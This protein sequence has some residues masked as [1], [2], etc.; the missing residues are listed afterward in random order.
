MRKN[1]A[2]SVKCVGAAPVARCP[3]VPP[4][5]AGKEAVFTHNAPLPVYISHAA[6]KPARLECGVCSQ[7]D[8][9][10]RPAMAS[11][12]SKGPRARTT[13]FQQERAGGLTYRIPSLVH[14]PGGGVVLAFAEKRTTPDDT[15]AE[16][17]VLRRGRVNGR[18]VQW[19]PVKELYCATLPGHRTMNP[20]PVYER[21]SKTLFLFFICVLRK[22]SERHQICTGKNAARLCYVTSRDEGQSWSELTDLTDGVLGERVDW[23][24][25]AVGPGH[26][27]QTAG[28]K[29]VVPAYAY[30]VHCRCFCFPLY[31]RPHA[32]YFYSTDGGGSWLVGQ[33]V[34]RASCECEMAEVMD[35]EHRGHVY[36]NA[37]S[38]CGHRVEAVGNSDGTN[39]GKPRVARQLVEQHHGCQGSVVGFPAP[40]PDP[41]ERNGASACL[42]DSPTWLLFSHPTDRRRRK[43]LGVYLNRRPLHESS[44]ERLCVVNPGPSGYSDLAYCEEEGLF[45][46][47]VECGKK[48]EVEQIASL[49]FSLSDLLGATA[50]KTDTV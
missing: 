24:T 12:T 17:L 43:N 9:L 14:V 19:L 7:P 44:W 39:F 29:L 10:Q 26:G 3:P 6:R 23:A 22:T 11:D 48:S 46:C 20:C 42:L 2:V 27:I 34:H 37:R 41:G 15:D 47:L 13:V 36:C 5:G 28:G 32:F 38:T 18:S 4:T 1:T 50:A 21:N 40:K 31:V 33:A 45:V 49:C 35:R 16:L 30:Q 25:F 8:P